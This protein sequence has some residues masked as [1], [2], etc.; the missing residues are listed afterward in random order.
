MPGSGFEP[1]TVWL[2]GKYATTALFS[3][4]VDTK[5]DNTRFFFVH[6]SCVKIAS[7][8]EELSNLVVETR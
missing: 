1:R 6:L 7:K 5:N 3:L 8:E 4:K 2:G